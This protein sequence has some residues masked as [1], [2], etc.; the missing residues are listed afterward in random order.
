[1]T[2]NRRFFLAGTAA[3]VTFAGAAAQAQDALENVMSSGVIRIAVPTDYPPYGFVGLNL[4]S[5]GL[6]IDMASLIAEKLGVELKMVPVTSANR[7]PYLQTGQVDLVISTLGKNAERMEVIDFTHA[8]AP[9]FQAVYGPKSMAIETFDDLDG[10]TIAVAKGAM[11]EPELAKLGP[12]G[13]IFKRYE[14][15]ASA[16]AAFV[17]GQTDVIA[18]STSNAALMAKKNPHLDAELKKIIKESPCFV[19]IAKEQDALRG[20]VNEIILAAKAD[21]TI[22]AMSQKWLGKAAGDLPLT[23]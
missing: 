22:D 2:L 16:T 21:G 11:E 23:E 4:E 17:A 6:D 19:G 10:K 1:M 13:M 15:Q 3:L 14:D 9:F 7:I 8:Y 12:D 20:K 18:T 5:Q